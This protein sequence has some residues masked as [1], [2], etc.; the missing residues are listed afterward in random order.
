[1]SILGRTRL[2]L[3]TDTASFDA[4][5]DVLRRA[6]PQ[7]WRGNDVQFELALFFNGA[8]LEVSNLASLTLEIRPLGANAARRTA[9]L[10]P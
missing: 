10:R 8:L 9:A 2:R 7:F 1:M 6:T 4:P 3:A 5:L